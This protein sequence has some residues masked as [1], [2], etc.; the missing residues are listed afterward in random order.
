MIGTDFNQKDLFYSAE[1]KEGE[2]AGH[3]A[4]E[5][6]CENWNSSK[7]ALTAIQAVLPKKVIIV[8]IIGL[9]IIIGDKVQEKFCK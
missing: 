7:M 1:I 5:I 2:Y 8:W 3:K 9:V 6:F 4:K